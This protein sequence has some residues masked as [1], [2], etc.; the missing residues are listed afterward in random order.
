MGKLIDGLNEFLGKLKRPTTEVIEKVH[1][2]TGEIEIR[3][4]AI[5]GGID[6]DSDYTTVTH[7][8]GAGSVNTNFG[9]DGERGRKVIVDPVLGE[10]TVFQRRRPLLD[11]D[12]N[13]VYDFTN[14]PIR[15]VEGFIAPG[16][17]NDDAF[18]ESVWDQV[19]Q[20]TRRGVEK[21]RDVGVPEDGWESDLVNPIKI[22]PKSGKIET[23]NQPINNNMNIDNLLRNVIASGAASIPVSLVSG[24]GLGQT[25]IN[26]LA[27]GAGAGIGTP[28]A[29]SYGALGGAV[30]GNVLANVFGTDRNESNI[31]NLAVGVVNSTAEEQ[32]MREYGKAM[33]EANLA[34]REMMPQSKQDEADTITKQKMETARAATKPI[35]D[36]RIEITPEDAAR[37]NQIIERI[38]ASQ[39]Q[40]VVVT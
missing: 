25:A 23:I 17:Y 1:P 2:V 40:A 14:R 36:Q 26:A 33:L 3:P 15:V 22:L 16:K 21:M 29:G 32:A 9:I 39:P 18:D 19:M 5:T 11:N 30:A 13:Q 35:L 6:T 20:S 37:V 24:Q 38:I 7:S 8:V 12:G 28:I 34:L 10:S 31:N 27:T 4:Y